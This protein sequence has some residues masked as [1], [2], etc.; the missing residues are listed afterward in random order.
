M[1]PVPDSPAD[2]DAADVAD[3]A[4]RR[5]VDWRGVI[6]FVALA[7]AGAW[8]VASLLWLSGRGLAAPWAPAVLGAMMFTVH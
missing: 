4:A 3:G 6:W 2:P 7:Y 5:G 8:L 1:Q